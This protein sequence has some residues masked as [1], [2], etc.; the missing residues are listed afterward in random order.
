MTSVQNFFT[1]VLLAPSCT[2]SARHA[3]K[4][5]LHPC[6]TATRPRRRL[7]GSRRPVA[8]SHAADEQAVESERVDDAPDVPDSSEVPASLLAM[9]QQR[10][11]ARARGF[12]AFAAK[13]EKREKDAARAK[14]GKAKRNR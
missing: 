10:D 8:S 5:P 6:C 4:S 3:C 12:D 1:P 7:V 9:F 11:A 14:P 13:W 2:Q